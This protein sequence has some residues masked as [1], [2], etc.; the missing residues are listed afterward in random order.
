MNWWLWAL[1]GCSSPV[2]CD[3]EVR[4]EPSDGGEPVVTCARVASSDAARREG[5]KGAAALGD[6]EGLW[7]AYPV[8]SAACIT[9]DGVDQPLD[10]HFVA[11]DGRVVHSACGLA[12]GASEPVCHDGTAAVLERAPEPTCEQ[13]RG[14]FIEESLAKQWFVPPPQELSPCP[15]RPEVQVSG[16]LILDV[17]RHPDVTDGAL[18]R[19]LGGASR[20]WGS[21]GLWLTLDEPPHTEAIEPVLEGIRRDLDASVREAGLAPDDPSPEVQAK[22]RQLVIRQVT[23]PLREQLAQRAVPYRKHTA[24]VVVLPEIGRP[25]SVAEALFERLRGL[26]LSPWLRD[27]VSAE[28]K[29]LY[30]VLEL[31]ERFTP[32]VFVGTRPLSEVGPEIDVTLAHELGHAMGLPHA[33]ARTDLM[34]DAVHRCEPGLSKGQAEQLMGYRRFRAP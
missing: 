21:H 31:P 3:R 24:V 8:P 14:S 2:P 23:R 30:D 32:V 12:A 19:I 20:W 11:A 26:T 9:M 22:A 5:L 28:E 33:E 34:A 10:V 29:A 18:R 1:V 16:Q 27:R 4:F 25:G 17:V 13:W 7:L 15:G 6:D